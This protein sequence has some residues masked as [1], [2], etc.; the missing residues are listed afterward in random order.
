MNAAGLISGTPT[1]EETR[2]VTVTV[3]DSRGLSA[4]KDFTITV[5]PPIPVLSAPSLPTSVLPAHATPVAFVLASPFPS[6]LAGKLVMTFTSKADVAGDDPMTRFSNGTRTVAFTIPANSTAAV[7]DTPVSLTAGT[8][9]GTIRLAANFD[10]GPQDVTVATT[11]ITSTPPTITN[12]VALRTGNGLEVQITGYAP[13]RKITTAEFTFDLIKGGKASRETVVAN[14]VGT[15][16]AAWFTSP[17]SIQFGSAFSYLQSF[18]YSGGN[19]NDVQ[20]VTVRLTNAQ[21]STT[22]Q[23]IN[24]K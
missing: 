23:V 9:A 8:V 3:T 21:G 20:S 24:F 12:V 15:T 13:S 17:T 1:N 7:F 14:A 16:F 6:P 22:S 5:D 10:N 2:V 18:D 19:V 4:S 11:E